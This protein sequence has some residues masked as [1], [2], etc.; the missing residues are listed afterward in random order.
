MNTIGHRIR[1]RRQKLGIT[2]Q[3]IA[4]EFGIARVSVTQWENDITSPQRDRI[5]TLAQVLKCSPEW[6]LKGN[7]AK[8][9]G[10]A[11]IQAGV[12]RA[13]EMKYIKPEIFEI[14]LASPISMKIMISGSPIVFEVSKISF[15]GKSR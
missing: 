11:K 5:T 1:E 2:Q 6:L 4:D 13:K 15:S 7:A 8:A 14:E 12:K 3:E 9:R 10:I